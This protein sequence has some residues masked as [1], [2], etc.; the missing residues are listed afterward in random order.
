[1]VE[2]REATAADQEDVLGL[3][4]QLMSAAT[5]ESAINQPSGIEV[6][7]ELLDGRA[8]SVLVAEEDGVILGLI[9]LSYPVAIRCGGPYSCI[10]E[11]IVSERARGKGVGGRL[12]EAAIAKAAERGCFELQVNRPSDLGYPVYIEHGWEDLGKHLS[13]RPVS[14]HL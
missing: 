9:T 8:G 10:E 11:F 5:E 3:L 12:L 1:M 6:F 13:L 4:R 7:R 2:V 14:S